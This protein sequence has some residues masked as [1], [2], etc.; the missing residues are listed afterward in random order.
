MKVTPNLGLSNTKDIIEAIAN[1]RGPEH[2]IIILG[3]AG[4][5]PFQLD[6]E[7]D[8]NAWLTCSV[9]EDII[10]RTPTDLRWEEAMMLM[11]NDSEMPSDIPG[12]L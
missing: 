10:F 12:F 7:I 9:V 11:G 4:W 2:F 3:C 5:G 6:H 1:G 8:D